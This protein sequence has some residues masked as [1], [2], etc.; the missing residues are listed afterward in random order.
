MIREKAATDQKFRGLNP[1]DI[2]SQKLAQFQ[3]VKSKELDIVPNSKKLRVRA[4]IDFDPRTTYSAEEA[5]TMLAFKQNA[6]LIILSCFTADW[7]VGYLEMP[8]GSYSIV[9]MLPSS[10][11]SPFYNELPTP[12]RKYELKDWDSFGCQNEDELNDMLNQAFLQQSVIFKSLQLVNF[13][14][15][16]S[17][18]FFFSDSVIYSEG[19]L[20]RLRQ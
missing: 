4:M 18:S 11:I 16:N 15:L 17:T 20:L 7:L 19:Q 14:S 8:A 13:A 3:D 2:V 6:K 12:Q 5:K 10:I 9:K 1:H